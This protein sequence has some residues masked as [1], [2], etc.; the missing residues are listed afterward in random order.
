MTIAI[1]LIKDSRYEK[2]PVLADDG[3][4]CPKV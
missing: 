3:K 1:F 4:L 2:P